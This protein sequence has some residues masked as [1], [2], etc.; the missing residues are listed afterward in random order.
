M[1]FMTLPTILA[2]AILLSGCGILQKN[3]TTV[4]VTDANNTTE[5]VSSQR[6]SKQNKTDKKS[7][8][9]KIRVSKS[10]TTQ[11]QSTLATEVINDQILNGEW[12]IN[13]VNGEKV[14]GDERPYVYF[15]TSQSRFYGSG[16]CNLINGDYIIDGNKITFDNVLSTQRM[17]DNAPYEYHINYGLTQSVSYEFSHKGNEYYLSLYDKY[18]VKILELHKHNMDFLNGAWQI[19][20]IDNNECDDESLKLVIDIPERKLHGNTGCNI[21]NGELLIDADKSNSIQFNQLITTM[22]SC[23]DQQREMTLLI[24]LE[25]VDSAHQ[26]SDGYVTLT[27][28]NGKCLLKLKK[29][30]LK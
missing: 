14:T 8:K 15:E 26:E 7:K 11:S 9:Q 22:K 3:T 18:N 5:A 29:I 24:S 2:T 28:K 27:D 19:V 20:S 16:G 12:T 4:T 6:Q 13:Q 23:H 30:L 10:V 21:V 25:E 17:C 1:K